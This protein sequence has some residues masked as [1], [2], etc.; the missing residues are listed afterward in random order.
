VKNDSKGMAFAAV[1]ATHAVAQ[2]YPVMAANAFDRPLVDG[3]DQ[4]V[5]WP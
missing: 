5:A 2:G 3:K 4:A 1:Q